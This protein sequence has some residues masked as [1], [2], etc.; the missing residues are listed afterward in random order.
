MADHSSKVVADLIESIYEY[1]LSDDASGGW[2]HIYNSLASLVGSGAGGMV[3]HP[4]GGANMKFITNSVD[5]FSLK[6]YLDYYQHVSPVRPL[7]AKT[8][9]GGTFSRRRSLSDG[10]FEATEYYQD[11]ARKYSVFEIE[12]HKL[13][14]YKGVTGAIG[15]TLPKHRPE[16]S[17][18]NRRLIDHVIPHL[19]RALGNYLKITRLRTENSALSAIIGSQPDAILVLDRRLQIVFAN[20]AAENLLRSAK[21]IERVDGALFIRRPNARK[22]LASLAKQIFEP[23]L[24]ANSDIDLRIAL[25]A[26]DEPDQMYLSVTVANNAVVDQAPADRYLIVM[27]T[28]SQPLA[29][30]MAVAGKYLLTPCE[31]QVAKLLAKGHTLK[32]ICEAMKIKHNTGRTHLKHIFAKTGVRRQHELVKLVLS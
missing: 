24:P 18:Q 23:L 30:V 25:S 29:G 22:A 6:E 5:L 8:P 17:R 2:D 20:D 12:Y 4:G 15:F 9:N 11:Y 1:S 26:P 31:T 14:R 13:S 27:A 3:I 16:F 19:R 7:L 10:D 32:E 21:G 28:Q